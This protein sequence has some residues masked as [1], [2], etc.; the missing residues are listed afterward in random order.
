MF[1]LIFFCRYFI[2][3]TNVNES[4]KLQTGAFEENEIK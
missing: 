3:M 4:R 2:V 1:N